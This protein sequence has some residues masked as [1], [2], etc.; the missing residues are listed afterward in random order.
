MP[1]SADCYPGSERA[2]WPWESEGHPETGLVT[3]GL[4]IPGLGVLAPDLNPT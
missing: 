3:L 4:Q 1:S 2:P